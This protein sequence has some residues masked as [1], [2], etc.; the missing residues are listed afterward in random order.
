[1]A[2]TLEIHQRRR[3]GRLEGGLERER[4]WELSIDLFRTISKNKKIRYMEVLFV[5]LAGIC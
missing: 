1:M 3:G 5:N 4:G 2:K